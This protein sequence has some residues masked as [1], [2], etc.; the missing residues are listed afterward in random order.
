MYSRRATKGRDS[1]AVSADCENRAGAARENNKKPT[2]SRDPR[3][4]GWCFRR[5]GS[6]AAPLWTVGWATWQRP[7]AAIR[8]PI[9]TCGSPRSG[10]EVVHP[11][12]SRIV[13]ATS[14]LVGCGGP[15][16]ALRQ[17]RVPIGRRVPNTDVLRVQGRRRSFGQRPRGGRPVSHRH[18]RLGQVGASVAPS[19][20]S[21]PHA[22]AAGLS[23]CSAL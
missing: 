11:S 1:E 8:P 23:G 7:A 18:R 17:S 9:A 12:A 15:R 3:R 16:L 13:G 20:P 19:L 4:A 10:G 6:V 22:L 21:S 14:T 2:E 5:C